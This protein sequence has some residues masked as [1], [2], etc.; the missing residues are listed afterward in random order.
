MKCICKKCGEVF[1]VSDT[2]ELSTMK[3]PKCAGTKIKF[4]SPNKKKKK[5][6]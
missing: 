5:Q 2:L 1:I 4:E 6:E 3:C